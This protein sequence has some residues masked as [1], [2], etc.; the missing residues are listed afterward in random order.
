MAIDTHSTNREVIIVQTQN[1]YGSR[2]HYYHF[3]FG[4]L[5][6]LL[7]WVQNNDAFMK[8]YNLI[9]QSCGPMDIHL[10]IFPENYITILKKDKH[11]KA[12]SSKAYR[13]IALEGFDTP[14]EYP[15][16][17]IKYSTGALKKLLKTHC[18]YDFLNNSLESS[19]IP[20]VLLVERL[21][22]PDQE[23]AL[24]TEA[25]RSGA[26]RRSIP[27]IRELDK[28]LK[29]YNSKIVHFEL[30]DLASQKKIIEQTSILV[31]QHGAALANIILSNKKL[32]IIE[33]TPKNKLAEI[34]ETGDYFGSL[35]KLLG[36]N[37]QRISQDN[38]HAK[39]DIELIK[40]KILEKLRIINL[41]NQSQQKSRSLGTGC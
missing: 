30:I 5:L 18:T 34:Q 36:H 33:I 7:E 20:L 41:K 40:R 2:E 26:Q 10:K 32:Y 9:I 11:A 17:R 13:S 31:A 38:D 27:N 14:K 15:I 21:P 6:P 19:G 29:K 3:L 4:C 1:Q 39:V 24:R 35:S 23:K 28:L 8:K 25:L 22:P 16:E 12:F 37:F